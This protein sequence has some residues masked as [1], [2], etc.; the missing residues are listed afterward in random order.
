MS[1]IKKYLESFDQTFEEHVAETNTFEG[2]PEDGIYHVMVDSVSLEVSKNNNYM[3]M[4]VLKII[5]D[6]KYAGYFLYKTSLLMTK[7]NIRWLKDELSV[8]QLYLNKISDLPNCLESLLDIGLEIIK[9]TK[10]KDKNSKFY[11]I[12]FKKRIPVFSND[13]EEKNDIPF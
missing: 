10:E 8:C 12:Y 4:W 9:K 5:D 13:I 1:K 6:D 7:E 2:I 3:L 11:N